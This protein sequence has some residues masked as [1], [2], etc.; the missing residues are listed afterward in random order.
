MKQFVNE[1]WPGIKV[2]FIVLFRKIFGKDIGNFFDNNFVSGISLCIISVGFIVIIYDLVI[3]YKHKNNNNTNTN[4]EITV[5]NEEDMSKEI[6]KDPMSRP[7]YSGEE[8]GPCP[9]CE[10]PIVIARKSRKTEELYFGCA[11]PKYGPK[12]GCNFKGC[13]SH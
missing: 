12:R 11:A 5:N 1:F 7:D 3:K 10:Y 4:K 13:R 6:K 9:V 2:F 8:T